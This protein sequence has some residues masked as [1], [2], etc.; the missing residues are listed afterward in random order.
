MN[1]YFTILENDDKNCSGALGIANVL[2]E[3]GKIREANEIYKALTQYEPNSQTGLQA[4]INQAHVAMWDKNFDLSVNLYS[5]AL[6]AQ[7]NNLDISL[8]LSKAF[9]KKQDYPSCQEVLTKLSNLYP[10]DPRIGYN[11]AHCLYK[12]AGETYK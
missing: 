3:Y 1:Q 2:N 7:P 12:S 10:S 4:R 9:F 6:E 11:L 8:Y 5:A